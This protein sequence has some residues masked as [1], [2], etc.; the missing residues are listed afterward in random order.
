MIGSSHQLTLSRI[1]QRSD[2]VSK[3]WNSQILKNLPVTS[4]P[5]CVGSNANTLR[6]KHLQFPGMG[7]SSGPA[8]GA[9]VV[10][11]RT[12]KLLT[13]QHSIS[14]GRTTSLNAC[15]TNQPESF[16]SMHINVPCFV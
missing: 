3:E 4:V 13:K 7:A 5:R 9:R 2:A 14:D 6:L 8:D 16:D 12:D 15:V 1:S 11:H 10:H